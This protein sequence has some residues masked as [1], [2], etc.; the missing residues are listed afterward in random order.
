MVNTHLYNM[1]FQEI[2]ITSS[3]SLHGVQNG[4][5]QMML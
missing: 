3:D 4:N 2:L 5:N 1:T